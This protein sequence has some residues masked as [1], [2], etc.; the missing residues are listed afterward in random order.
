MITTAHI[1]DRFETDGTVHDVYKQRSGR[2]CTLKHPTS[3][4]MALEQFTWSP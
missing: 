1:H 2:P 3:S 4:A